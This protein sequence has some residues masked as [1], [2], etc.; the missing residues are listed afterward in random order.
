DHAGESDN[1]RKPAD[2]VADVAPDHGRAPPDRDQNRENRRSDQREDE[3]HVFAG[4][5][6]L[7]LRVRQE[8]VEREP[9]KVA[10]DEQLDEELT[11]CAPISVRAYHADAADPR[12]WR[13]IPPSAPASD[14]SRA[15]GRNRPRP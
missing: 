12:T 10:Q 1:D 3:R 8:D 9:R 4:M 7:V 2:R 13:A 15:T 5:A 6:K 14:N 11:V